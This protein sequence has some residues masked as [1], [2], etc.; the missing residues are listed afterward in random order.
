MY[1]VY[2]G[3]DSE[4]FNLFSDVLEH[5]Q[6]LLQNGFN[7]ELVSSL[8]EIDDETIFVEEVLSIESCRVAD[9]QNLIDSYT[10]EDD[11]W[12][13]LDDICDRKLDIDTDLTKIN[14]LL[15]TPTKFSLNHLA[16]LDERF[17][18]LAD[19]WHRL[20]VEE[21]DIRRKLDMDAATC[22]TQEFYELALYLESKI[23]E[24]GSQLEANEY[25]EVWKGKIEREI[26]HLKKGLKLFKKLQKNHENQ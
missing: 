22:D 18:S 4:E 15:R 21:I 2:V 26:K 3:E 10:N 14:E 8:D 20:N 5:I 23:D 12:D 1:R 7:F 16:E 25:S 11:Y 19:E 24:L 6:S 9:I 17:D 13:R